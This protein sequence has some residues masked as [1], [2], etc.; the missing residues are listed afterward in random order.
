MFPAVWKRSAGEKLLSLN[1]SGTFA[2]ASTS[3]YDFADNV[4]E[5]KE[6]CTAEMQR[7]R[8]KVKSLKLRC[9]A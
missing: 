5:V 8:E 3:L 9:E 2:I 6:L 7:E 1:E 4:N